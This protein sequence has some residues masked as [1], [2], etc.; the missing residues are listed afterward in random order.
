MKN[1]YK[2]NDY[3]ISN[4]KLLGFHYNEEA[5][6]LEQKCYSLRFPVVKYNEYANINA[7][8]TINSYNGEININVYDLKGNFYPPFYNQ[9]YGDFNDI[10]KIIDRNINKKLK[11]LKI[12]RK[13]SDLKIPWLKK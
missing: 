10:L 5:S 4:L 2:I 1:K 6:N 7:E 9:K 3:S 11:C 13:E 12:K 8:I